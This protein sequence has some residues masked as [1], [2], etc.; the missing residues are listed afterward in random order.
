[1]HVRFSH[2]SAGELKRILKLKLKDFEQIE[3]V[4]I[5]HWYQENGKFHSS[6]AEGKMKE[7]A[8]IKSSIVTAGDIM[9]V[10]GARD[11]NKP[12]LIHIDV[13]TK[14]IIPLKIDQRRCVLM[15]SCRLRR[16]MLG[17]IID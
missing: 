8:K 9:F 5:D 17:T 3:P 7:H 6:C 10:E 16:Y 11:I 1:M 13:C 2:A 14:V 15:Q 12:L 4:D